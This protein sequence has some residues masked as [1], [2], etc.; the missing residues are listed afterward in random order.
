MSNFDL[1]KFI[2]EQRT[3]KVKDVKEET[4][5]EFDAGVVAVGAPIVMSVVASGIAKLGFDKIMQAIARIDKDKF[6][7]F[8]D[9]YASTFEEGHDM[10]EAHDEMEEAVNEAHDE[11]EEGEMNEDIGKVIDFIM[12]NVDKSADWIKKNIK[13]GSMHQAMSSEAH[14]E[15]EE[16][17]DEMEE[18]EIDESV[19]A[20]VAA[21]IGSTLAATKVLDFIQKKYPEAVKKFVKAVEA[22]EKASYRRMEEGD[23]KEMEESL[24]ESDEK[25]KASIKEILNS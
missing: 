19:V 1:R 16:A 11:M 9:K 13:V 14:D 2:A 15:M 18:G 5:K 23:D 8:V 6:K 10:E 21:L 25:F 20:G 3:A 24:N 22:G 17:H 7:K 4:I 12:Q